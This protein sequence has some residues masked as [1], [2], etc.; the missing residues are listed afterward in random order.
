MSPCECYQKNSILLINSYKILFSWEWVGIS[1]S[2]VIYVAE[3][4]VDWNRFVFLLYISPCKLRTV[5]KDENYVSRENNTFSVYFKHRTRTAVRVEG[6][7]NELCLWVETHLSSFFIVSG[8]TAEL[9][10]LRV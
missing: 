10:G 5:E 9:A 1:P 7:E 6:T 4:W 2:L 8:G 3:L